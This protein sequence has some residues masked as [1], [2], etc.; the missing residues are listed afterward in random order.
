[1]FHSHGI[2]EPD[3]PTAHRRWVFMNAALMT[4]HMPAPSTATS[5]LCWVGS[6]AT[7]VVDTTSRTV[8]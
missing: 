8:A 3:N 2:H 7:P 6:T 1:M 4:N 5:R